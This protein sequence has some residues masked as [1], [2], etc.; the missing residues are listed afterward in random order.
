[1]NDFKRSPL[2]A[3]LYLAGPIGGLTW[4]EATGWRD[5]VASLLAPMKTRSPL[6][7]IMFEGQLVD[8]RDSCYVNDG[9]VLSNSREREAITIP[10][11]HLFKR[12]YMD[13]HE[14]DGLFVNFIGAKKKSVGTV[15]EI[16]WAYRRGIPIVIVMEPGNLNEDVFLERMFTGRRF[17]TLA[18]G[19]NYMRGFFGWPSY[20][21]NGSD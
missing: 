15:C 14:C 8:L 2:K 5:N 16:S 21:A 4:D 18:D 12:D 1:M 11:E 17:N 20:D 13:C 10:F 3:D 9:A 19:V 7:P 6:R